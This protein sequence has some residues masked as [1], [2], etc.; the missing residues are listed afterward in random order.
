MGLTELLLPAIVILVALAFLNVPLYLAIL[1]A[2]MYIAFTMGLSLD[3][4][5][6]GMFNNIAKTSFLCIPFFLLTG[7]LIQTSTM[8]IRLINLFMVLLQHTK[9]GLAIACLLANAVF[10]AISG[11]SPAAVATFGRVV[12]GPLAKVQGEKLSLGIITSSGALSTIIPPSIMLIVFGIATDTSITRL[13]M[14]G[15][16]PGV[17]LVIIV[18][19]YLQWRCGKNIKLKLYENALKPRASMKEL[20]EVTIKAI[21]T[22]VLPVIILGGIYSGLFTP[23]EAAAISAIYCFIVSVFVLRDI[24][25][26]KVPRVLVDACR[27]TGQ[28]FI[29]VAVSTLFAQVLTMAQVPGMITEGF[30]SLE[31]VTFLLML[32]VVLLIIGCFFDTAAAILILAPLLMPAALALGINPIHL[33]IVFTV[34]LSIGMFT[35]PF[36]MN[37]FVA[38]SILERSM[39]TI[40][41][42]VV[43]YICLYVV[44]LFIITYIPQI[45][46]FLPELLL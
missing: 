1:V 4:M 45:A 30:S 15:F 46:L 37:I 10:G 14:A 26:R 8:G 25:L 36:G 34:N 44:G 7:T 38:Q 2:T 19:I 16:L 21:P 24:N 41:R 43:P 17:V 35:P 12:F 23:T 3:G 13:F 39:G 22:L 32:N 9:A 33:G 29:L 31:R 6:S 28:T 11:S 40:A 18:A 27:V 5:F 20:R 42:A